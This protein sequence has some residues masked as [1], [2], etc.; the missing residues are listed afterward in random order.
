MLE[1]QVSPAG[2]GERPIL[3]NLLQFYIHDFSEYWAGEERGEIE[4]DGRFRDYPLDGYWG[5]PGHVPLMFRLKGR[6]AGFALVNP[7]GHIGAALDYNMAEFFVARK[8]R[9]A[10]LGLSAAH[11]IF[12]RYPGRWEVAVARRNPRALG[13]WRRAIRTCSSAHD[14]VEVD[15]SGGNVWD[16]RVFGFAVG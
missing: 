3:A 11:S 8:H 13:F 14:L 7:H 2:V 1:L 6:F 16:G 4:D 15:L 9:G 5:D 12:D 10:G